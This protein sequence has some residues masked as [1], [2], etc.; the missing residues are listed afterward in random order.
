ME[1]VRLGAQLRLQELN[2]ERNALL[3]ILEIKDSDVKKSKNIIDSLK[4]K[5][6]HWSQTKEGKAYLSK[7]MKAKWR[8]RK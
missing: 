5:K 7:I 3:K 1:L 4:P 2:K 8:D 6:K